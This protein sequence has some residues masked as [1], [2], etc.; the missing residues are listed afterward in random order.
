MVRERAVEVGEEDLELEGQAVEHAGHDE[1]AHAVRGIGHH[2]ERTEHGPVDEGA[3]VGRVVV[4]EAR[5][6]DPALG[7]G[8]GRYPLLDQ[9]ADLLQPGVLAHRPG[10][11]EAELDAVVARRVVRRGEHGPRPV[12]L[13]GRVVDE[14]GGGE[15]QVDDVDAL[16]GR[17]LGE[18]ARELDARL[19]HVARHDDAR[20]SREAGERGTDAPGHVGVELV[21]H[22]APYVVGLEDR[23]QVR[24]R[25]G[26]P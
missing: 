19:A 18:R 14:V 20:G 13:A 2:L 15:P 21:G 17:A 1:P 22:R 3:H 10:A 9:P 4:D 7:A 25:E 24:H 11:G 16:G 6:G 8:G 5:L 26:S 23:A 12:E